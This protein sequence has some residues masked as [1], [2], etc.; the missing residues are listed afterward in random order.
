MGV[1]WLAHKV[2]SGK[3]NNGCLTLEK[4]RTHELLSLGVSVKCWRLG[5]FWEDTVLQSVLEAGRSWLWYQQRHRCNS[6]GEGKQATSDISFSLLS[7]LLPDGTATISLP[8]PNN[9]P[10]WS[11]TG[12]PSSSHFD[13]FQIQS[14]PQPRLTITDG[15][16]LE[17]YTSE[18]YQPRTS[19]CEN[20]PRIEVWGTPSR[21]L[22]IYLSAFTCVS[23]SR[24]S[25]SSTVH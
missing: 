12:V 21:Q 14:I 7:E 8:T 22:A 20:F 23:C 18:Q 6:K 15:L 5:G 1:I 16:W 17:E 10:R 3:S 13:W 11:L 9:S 4:L 19:C 2:P 25:Y 24:N